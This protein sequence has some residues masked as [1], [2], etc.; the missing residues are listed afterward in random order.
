MEQ[1][2]PAALPLSAAPPE[3]LT[4]QCSSTSRL[5]LFTAT[6]TDWTK[7][8]EEMAGTQQLCGAA[9]DHSCNASASNPHLPCKLPHR[10][11]E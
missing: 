3:T 11:G 2:Q 10:H 1:T 9:A 6:W 5:G 8:R 4:R 7:S